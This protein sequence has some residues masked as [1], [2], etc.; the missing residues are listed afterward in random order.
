MEQRTL[1]HTVRHDWM[2]K[3]TTTPTHAPRVGMKRNQHSQV[4]R[5]WGKIFVYN[6]NTYILYDQV[7]YGQQY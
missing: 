3:T 5:S 7:N 2:Q 1:P 6:I 4:L